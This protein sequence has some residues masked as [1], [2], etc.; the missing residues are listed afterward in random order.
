MTP[1]RYGQFT[2]ALLQSV[3]D[4]AQVVGLVALGS[5]AAQD[6]APDAWSDHDFFLVVAPGVQETFRGDLSWLPEAARIALSFR[7]TAHGLKVVYDDGHLLEFAVFDPEELFLARVNRYRVLLDRAD[8]AVRLAEIARRT[9]ASTAPPD[10][11]WLAGQV[12]TQL[13]VAAGRTRRGERLSG[14]A[15]LMGA[16]RHLLTLAAIV[17]TGPERG[18]LDGLDPHRRVERVFPE[19]ARAL[20][21]ALQRDGVAA[22]AAVLDLVE[23]SLAPRVPELSPRAIAAVRSALVRMR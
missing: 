5:M 6:Y 19:F 12:L 22:V 3:T 14:R 17:L 2:Q 4:R 21:Q 8:V 16:V 9:T 18:L 11:A 13:L 10:V 15:V 1:E 20:G 23:T 7:E